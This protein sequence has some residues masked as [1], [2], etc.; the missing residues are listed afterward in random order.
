[1]KKRLLFSFTVLGSAIL[2]FAASCS[3]SDTTT[4]ANA[5]AAG[6]WSG[7]Y[8]GAGGPSHI[9]S[10]NLLTNGNITVSANDPVSPDIANGTWSLVADS[11]RATYTYVTTSV[12]NSLAGKYTAGATV[13]V[14]TIGAGNSTTGIATFNLTK[15]N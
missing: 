3:K 13:M 2:L 15:Q 12:T 11:V 9:I 7:T 10:L 4:P 14:G 8:V 1:M 6:K 5:T